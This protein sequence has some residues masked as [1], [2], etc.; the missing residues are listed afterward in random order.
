[1]PL[2]N[3]DSSRHMALRALGTITH[4]GGVPIRMEIAKY[5]STLVKLIEEFSDDKS[6]V[7]PAIATLAHCANTVFGEN[8]LA[9]SKLLASLDIWTIVKVVTE[10]ARKEWASAHLINHAVSLLPM[11][12]LHA[13][14]ACKSYPPM[15]RFLVAGLRSKDWVTR[16]ICLG[17][18]IRLHRKESEPDTRL[19]DPMAF[20][21]A[22]QRGFP[23]HL[24]N[25][26][27]TYGLMRCDTYLTLSTSR[28][29]QQA[30][31]SS[32]HNHDLY[33]LGLK[34]AE[35]ILRTE[36]SIPDGSFQAEDPIT[37]KVETMDVGL[38]FIRYID[39]LPHCARAIR[40][41][42][43]A[44]GADLADILD[45]KFSIIRQRIPEAVD[46]AKKA[47]KR[48]PEGAYFY[49]AITL[50]AD[51]VEGLRAAKKV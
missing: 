23:P 47:L 48:N 3:I 5:S 46:L 18:I 29:F 27:L 4:H 40:A 35:F 14:D 16:C 43:I 22:I 41:R 9:D 26:M 7:E 51:H 17:G 19:L 31:I 10:N 45:I 36:F 37:G 44:S 32:A 42:R 28:D 25:L 12:T 49:Y 30:I 38:P 6:V 8:S 33:A 1:M 2:I 34:M 13:T 21:A 50:S 15:I 11:S 24:Q 39:A 20:I